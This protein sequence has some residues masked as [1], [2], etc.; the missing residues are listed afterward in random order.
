[1]ITCPKCGNTKSFFEV[2]IGGARREEYEQQPN[3]R[4]E[5]VG[6]DYSKVDATNFECGKCGIKVNFMYHKFLDKLFEP[7]NEKKHG[8]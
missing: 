4:W 8:I 7:Y 6:S 5:F 1:M 2:H 3:G